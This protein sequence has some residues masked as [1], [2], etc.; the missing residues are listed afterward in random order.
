MPLNDNSA[1]SE[2]SVPP[3]PAN[4]KSNATSNEMAINE[5]FGVAY[6]LIFGLFGVPS[7]N[8]VDGCQNPHKSSGV[9]WVLMRAP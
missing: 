2:G 8:G 6:P 5:G 9:G 1:S 4:L 7:S 3:T